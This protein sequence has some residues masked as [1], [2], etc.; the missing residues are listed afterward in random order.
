MKTILKAVALLHRAR[1]KKHAPLMILMAPR[2]GRYF[3]FEDK[4]T[5]VIAIGRVVEEFM[6]KR[7]NTY[8]NTTL[9]L[10]E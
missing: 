8:A 1:V 3:A 2:E 6:R 7:H 9:G 4:L 10:K 5:P